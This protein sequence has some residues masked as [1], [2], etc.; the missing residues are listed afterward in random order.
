[1]FF[2]L[3]PNAM[4]S[5]VSPDLTTYSKP[6]SGVD[7]LLVTGGSLGATMEDF[8]GWGGG[9]SSTF[10]RFSSWVWIFSASSMRL[11]S[12]SLIA[13]SSGVK[14]SWRAWVVVGLAHSARQRST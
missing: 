11:R 6:F 4:A 8:L 12:T 9:V 13:F 2:S 3:Q 1:M 10:R 5:S 7:E 14:S